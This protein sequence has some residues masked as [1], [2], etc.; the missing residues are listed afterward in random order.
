MIAAE[1]MIPHGDKVDRPAVEKMSPRIVTTSWDDGDVCDFRLVEMLRARNLLA[2]FYIPISG[3]HGSRALGPSEIQAM[4]SEGFEIGAHGFSHLVLPRCTNEVIIHEV[5]T[6]KQCLEDILGNEVRMFAYP[7]GRYSNA[8]IRFI[9]RA[10]YAGARTTEMLARGLNYDPYRM[11]TTVHAF[12]HSKPAYVRNTARA[13]HLARTWR[14]LTRL[15]RA[16]TWVDLAKVLFDSTL[17]EGGV[18]HLYGH[19]WEIDE[20]GLWG[21]LAEVLDYVSNRDGVRYLR[22]GEVLDYRV[23]KPFL[24]IEDHCA[25]EG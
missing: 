14:Y 23:E 25:T 9:K 24:P 2:T 22:N 6:S 5:E 17:E 12:P 8:A 11:P 7:R 18:F 10:G 15:R 16:N 21:D 1:K 19:S 13:A 3:H 20:L 4:V